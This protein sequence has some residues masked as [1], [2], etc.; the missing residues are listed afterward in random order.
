M[1]QLF[2]KIVQSNFNANKTV[3]KIKI[4]AI[5][6]VGVCLLDIYGINPTKF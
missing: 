1:K 2:K 4:R 6:N 3:L 5:L